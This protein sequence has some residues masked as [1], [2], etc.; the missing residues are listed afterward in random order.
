MSKSRNRAQFPSSIS[1]ATGT[2]KEQ[3]QV[4][5]QNLVSAPNSYSH[6]ITM[7]SFSNL[8]SLLHLRLY[9]LTCGLPLGEV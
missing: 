3:L 5:R 1:L 4:S 8:L 9:T 7:I 6:A 2:R